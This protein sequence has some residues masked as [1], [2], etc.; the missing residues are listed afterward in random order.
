MARGGR[1]VRALEVQIADSTTDAAES[2]IYPESL[3]QW[4]PS[5]VELGESEILALS[6]PEASSSYTVFD[7]IALSRERREVCLFSMFDR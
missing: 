2:L 5:F 4:W 3:P 7:M 6:S 1:K